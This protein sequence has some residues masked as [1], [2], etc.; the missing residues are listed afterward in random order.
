MQMVTS[1]SG[2]QLC[3]SLWARGRTDKGNLRCVQTVGGW[4]ALTKPSA[5]FWFSRLGLE[6]SAHCTPAQPQ[7]LIYPPY[8][9]THNHNVYIFPYICV[10]V[11]MC[12]LYIYMYVHAYIPTYIEVYL[13]PHIN[14]WNLSITI[15][16]K[17]DMKLCILCVI[18]C[19][20]V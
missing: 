16:Y 10:W 11:Y 1:H 12:V 17:I 8:C 5:V 7:P 2:A 13:F 18:F 20:C 6:W 15:S 14:Y 19:T 3:D 9:C 4:R